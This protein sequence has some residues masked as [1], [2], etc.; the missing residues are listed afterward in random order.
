M[1]VFVLVASSF[2][3]FS[4]V[5]AASFSDVPATHPYYKYI[6]KL[7]DA[8]I[9]KGVT[10][11]QYAPEKSLT[12]AEIA[13]L[14]VRIKG[15]AQ[16]TS[17][18]YF[19]DVAPGTWYYGYVNA[20]AKAGLVT[21]YP[22]GT[23][24][25]NNAISR[26]EL[27][28][29]SLRLLGVS[30][31]VIDNYAKNPIYLSSDEAKYTNHWAKG[32][33]TAAIM[34]KYQV[35]PW[36][37]PGR[38]IAPDAAANRGEAAY[39]F[40]KVKYPVKRGGQLYIIQEQEP[41][42]LFG[43]LDSM[44]AMTQVLALITDAEQGS[45]WR[46]NW[47]PQMGR[48][49]PTTDN[50][51]LVVYSTPQP[52]TLS[53]GTKVEIR[54]RVD[55]SLRKGLKWSD[56][57]EITVDDFIFGTLLYL[58]KDMPVPGL[59]P[60][61]RIAKIEKKDNYTISVYYTTSSVYIK[62][63]LPLYPK[64]WFETNVLKTTLTFPN[65]IEFVLK[66]DETDSYLS[67][68]SYTLPKTIKAAIDAKV[69]DIVNSAYNTKP[70]HTGPYKITNWVQK[71]YMEFVPD[72]NYFLGPGLFDKVV[73]A[74]RS[75]ESGL[76]E[77]LRGQPDVSI[78]GVINAQSAKTLS[79]NSTFLKT[80]KLHNIPSVY[81]EHWTVNF[82]D[83]NN[84][85][86]D[87]KPGTPYTHWAL[88]DYRVRQA[89]SYS[90]NRQDITNRIYYGMRPLCYNFVLPGTAFDEPTL[91][92]VFVYDPA[93]AAALL[94]EAGFTKG[95]DGIYAKGGKKLSLT[96]NTTT[97]VDRVQTLTLIQQ[98]FKTIGIGLT[99]APMN[100]G[101]FFNTVLPHRTYEIGEFAWGQNSI[102]EPGGSTL[103]ASWYI[104]SQAN[105][106]SGQNYSGF[107]NA[108]ADALIKKWDS[109]NMTERSNA[110]KTFAKNYFA[111]YMPEIPMLWYDQHDA[112]KLNIEGY[113][114]GLDVGAHTWNIAWW[115]RES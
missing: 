4:P 87:P 29:V 71:G 113:D 33:L 77:L 39:A 5:N 82:D 111:K 18:Q 52:M 25:P 69:E 59:E 95:S 73:V 3:G 37:M 2:V 12:R 17:K 43:A 112:V 100:S 93:K 102:L 72:N 105:G 23:F 114:C 57:K 106:Y 99:P 66:H 45:D 115:Y 20:A 56:G 58:A 107:R 94:Q 7:A 79:A 30:Q 42:T 11:T 16:D 10:A 74:F 19:K 26:A 65:T 54:A 60:Y 89:L 81:W 84:L 35:L 34:P 32:W 40:Y 27:A 67:D 24:K 75:V 85:P 68:V 70:L 62:Y 53:D 51:H 80:Y 92:N 98:Q 13:T 91:K 31:S 38:L 76:A 44:A 9:I 21:G 104:P 47:W 83:P 108:D 1:L 109:F 15:L 49:V 48:W 110:Y 28:V 55:Y 8:G 36:R 101:D 41:A 50:G 88:G 78:M 103:Y 96:A 46:G 90:I 14:L 6:I 97:R 22:D 64:H 63:G 86:A 61:D